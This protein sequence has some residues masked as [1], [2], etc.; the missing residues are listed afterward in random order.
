MEKIGEDDAGGRDEAEGPEGWE[1][2][3][4]ANDEGKEV[5]QGRDSNGGASD[6]QS[7]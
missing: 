6:T 5:S 3:I 7:R 1:R 4:G 2:A